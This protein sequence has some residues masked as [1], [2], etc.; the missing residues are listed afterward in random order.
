MLASDPGARGFED[1]AAV[2]EFGGESLVLTHDVL[3]EGVHVL[4]GQDAADIAW[5]LLAVNLSDLAAKGAAPLG[6]LLGYSLGG[7]DA[8]FI[9]GLREV[10]G[11][12]N[13]PLLGGDTVSAQGP[14]SWSM[15]AVG[16]ATHRPVPSRAGARVGDDVYVTG[17]LGTAMLGLEASRPGVGGDSTAYRRPVPRI[18]EGIALAPIVTAM[19][20]ISDG[21]LLDAWRMA[22][23][24]G[25]TIAI[26]SASVPVAD[27]ARRHECLCWGD[28][29][30]LLF[31]VPTG[32]HLPVMAHRVGA[33]ARPGKVSLVL[34]GEPQTDETRLGY[35]HG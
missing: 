5:K 10:L 13:V 30:E 31:T 29:Y 34:D 20:D 19:M 16:R 4:P 23:A 11:C 26:E 9:E 24:S 21:L 15:T 6:V 3:V 28:D 22:R 35:L 1:D 18:A 25:A 12:Y 33:V 8:G 27:P 17:M 7:D 32:T 14:R 2:L